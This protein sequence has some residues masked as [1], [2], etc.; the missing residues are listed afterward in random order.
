MMLV[1]K[2]GGRPL[3]ADPLAGKKEDSVAFGTGARRLCLLPWLAGGCGLRLRD[4]HAVNGDAVTTA[5]M[6]SRELRI[7]EGSKSM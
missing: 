3:I 5:W 1:S 2:S 7:H 4:Q 6:R